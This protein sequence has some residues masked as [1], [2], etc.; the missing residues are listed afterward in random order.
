MLVHPCT[1]VLHTFWNYGLADDCGP[2]SIGLFGP[3]DKAK[4]ARKQTK[5]LASPSLAPHFDFS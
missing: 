3:T 1:F 2:C 4:E 5:A